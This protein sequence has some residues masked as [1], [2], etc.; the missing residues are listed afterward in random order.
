MLSRMD[1]YPIHRQ[2][3]A[4]ARFLADAVAP[5]PGEAGDAPSANE[6]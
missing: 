2:A 5:A 3:R 6:E 1:D 4:A